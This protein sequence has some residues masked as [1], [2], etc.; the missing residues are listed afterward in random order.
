MWS[1]RSTDIKYTDY[2]NEKQLVRVVR[3]CARRAFELR[4]DSQTSGRL[5][6]GGLASTRVCRRKQQ[7]QQQ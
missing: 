1:R 3:Q 5:R 4:G 6:V 2:M 7:Q